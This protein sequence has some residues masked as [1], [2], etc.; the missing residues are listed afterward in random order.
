MAAHAAWTMPCAGLLLSIT[1]CACC[2]LPLCFQRL[3]IPI[4]DRHAIMPGDALA[5]PDF[6][7]SVAALAGVWCAGTKEWWWRASSSSGGVS[8][9]SCSGSC[10]TA[11]MRQGVRQQV[12]GG[13]PTLCP[14]IRIQYFPEWMSSTQDDGHSITCMYAC[15]LALAGRRSP[16]S[17]C[18]FRPERH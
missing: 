8:I 15:M 11:H 13:L 3:D 9:C 17:L 5:S 18:L 2:M 1:H 7:Q 4:W 10:C 6:K 16:A 12:P 14:S